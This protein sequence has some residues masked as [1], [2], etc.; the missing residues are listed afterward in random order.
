MEKNVLSMP[1]ACAQSPWKPRVPL[2]VPYRR[3]LSSN[4]TRTEHAMTSP[5]K[6]GPKPR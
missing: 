2:L 5:Q 1:I 6:F 3:K 4:Q